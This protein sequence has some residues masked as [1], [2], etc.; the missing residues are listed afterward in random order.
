MVEYG[1]RRSTAFYN[2]V[3]KKITPLDDVFLK[4]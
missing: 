2:F 4:T 3:V 1:K